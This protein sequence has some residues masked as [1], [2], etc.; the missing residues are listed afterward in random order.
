MPFQ[1][2]TLELGY[3]ITKN[4]GVIEAD[5]SQY[6]NLGLEWDAWHILALRA[7]AYQ[8][9]AQSDSVWLRRWV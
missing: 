9:L 7:G 5:E 8:N 2:F 1:D 3:D 4:K 6:V